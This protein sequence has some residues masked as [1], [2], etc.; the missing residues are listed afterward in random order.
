MGAS[1]PP[2]ALGWPPPKNLP[3]SFAARITN[4]SNGES[5]SLNLE[6]AN[7]PLSRL[8]G[9]MFRKKPAAILF[10][11][12]W[13][14]KH[15]IHSFFVSFPFDA[16]YLDGEGRVVDVF[17]KV[18]PFTA[19]L[20]PSKPVLYLV[21]LPPGLAKRLRIKRGNRLSISTRAEH[22]TITRTKSKAR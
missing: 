9:L 20:S 7:T 12:D 3:S 16:V 18:P 11:F 8:R 15:G 13:P 10:S 21:E 19:Y 4:Q 2:A 14:D 6:M 17:E 22:E 5:L 1:E